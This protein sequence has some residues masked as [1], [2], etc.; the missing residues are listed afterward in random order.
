LKTIV[1]LFDDMTQAKEAA[2]DLENAGIPHNDISLVANNETGQYVPTT[3]TTT[4]THAPSGYA[5]G[6]DAVVGAEIGG[7]AGLLLGLTAFAIPGLG[8]IAGAGWLMGMIYGAG[9]GAVA[10][11]LVGALIGWGIPE[12]HAKRYEAGIKSGGIVMGVRPRSDE[13][14]AYL[15]G[16][17]ATSG[18]HVYRGAAQSQRS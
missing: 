16:E 2:L 17:W 1:G 7:V 10:G 3:D 9:V 14:A 8:W 4:T 13:D 11:G 18:Q 15:E 6:H 12:E 5:I